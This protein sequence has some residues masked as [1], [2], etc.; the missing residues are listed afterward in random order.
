MNASFTIL[1]FIFKFMQTTHCSNCNHLLAENYQFCP[2]C[3]Q[4]K[5]IHRFT[6]GHLVHEFFHAFTHADKGI[7]HL[8][9]QLAIHPGQVLKEYIVEGKRKKYFN[10]FTFLLIVLGFT[11]I[12][13]SYVH[14]FTQEMKPE[15]RE[16]I[17][18]LPPEQQRNAIKIAEKSRIVNEF[19]E[20]KSNWVTLLSTPVISLVF[21]L[22]FRRRGLNY[23]EHLVAYVLMI[24]FLMLLTTIT[25]TPLMSLTKGSIYHYWIVVLNLLIQLLYFAWGYKGFLNLNTPKELLRVALAGF[26]GILLWV[27]VSISAVFIYFFL[28]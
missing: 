7:L 1:E 2:H 14:P 23:A 15:M 17:K 4:K 9:K 22:I 28:F 8:T 21:W 5:S 26:L 24:G 10:P 6:V 20:K 13:N 3:S 27:I 19:F 25:L 18:K 12:V 11:V 16:A